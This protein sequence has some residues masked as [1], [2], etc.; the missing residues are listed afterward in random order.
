MDI[1]TTKY[2]CKTLIHAV[3]EGHITVHEA[4]RHIFRMRSNNDVSMR[5]FNYLHYSWLKLAIT[6]ED[7]RAFI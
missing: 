7:M 3:D 2:K 4:M 1:R 5:V 6:D